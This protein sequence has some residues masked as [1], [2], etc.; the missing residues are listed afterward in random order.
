MNRRLTTTSEVLPLLLVA[1]VALALL[2]ALGGTPASASSTACRVRNTETGTT[3]AVLQAA[4][5]AASKGDRLTVTGTCHGTT[6]LDRD[7]FITGLETESSGRPILDGDAS[8]TVLTVLWAEVR[9]ESL[10]IEDGEAIRCWFPKVRRPCGGGIT[11]RGGTLN[12][13]DVVVRRNSGTDGGGIF[14]SGTLTLDG[15]TRV[16][17]NRSRGGAGVFNRK[18]TLTLLATSR[19]SRNDGGGIANGGTLILND[20]SSV[21]G[22]STWQGSGAVANGGSGTVTLNDASSIRDNQDLGVENHGTL[23]LNDASSIS[24]NETGV[25][26]DGTLTLNDDSRISRR[27]LGWGGQPGRRGR[28]QWLRQDH[29]QWS[30]P[31]YRGLLHRRR[32]PEHGGTI[33]L[34][35]QAR[36]SRN[37]NWGVYDLRG[38]ALTMTG[39]SSI[40]GNRGLGKR[41]GGVHKGTLLGVVCGPGGNVHGNTPDDCVE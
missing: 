21:S 25:E 14:T 8:D 1:I 2:M 3:Y 5:D 19:V 10:T 39:T 26:N 27:I 16:V 31:R 6:V 29:Q 18:G 15:T 33:T 23:T 4:V 41:G 34:N 37:R 9:I 36:V 20:S 7:L 28:P 30:V 22:N 13:R 32:R 12:L 35:D 40:V 17:A 38:G 11:N 24:G